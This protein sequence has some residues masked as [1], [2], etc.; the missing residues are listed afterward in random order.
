MEALK[1]QVVIVTGASRGI[2]AR[3]VQEFVKQGARVV[4]AARSEQSIQKLALEL[5]ENTLAVTCDVSQYASVE[6]LVNKTLQ[7][8]GKV[9]ALIN[10]AGVIDPI[11][12]LVESDPEGWDSVISI[13]LLGAYHGTRAV[14]PYFYTQQQG[15]I[16]NISSGAA[17]RPLEAWSAYCVSKAGLAMLTQTTALETSHVGISVYG[18]APGLVDT[19]MQAT[20]RAAGFNEVSRLPREKL[21][22]PDDAAKAIVW[23]CANKPQNLNGKDLDIR[24]S[25]LRSLIGLEIKS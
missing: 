1:D 8:F 21:S 18:L 6:S 13:N 12:H 2:G 7:H 19:E 11:S 24:E 15:T 4:L 20:I 5:G 10:N 9:T 25:D 16:I 3:T 23:L 17:F 22:S 14:L